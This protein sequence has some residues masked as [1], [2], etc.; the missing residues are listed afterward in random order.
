M[1]VKEYLEKD[2]DNTSSLENEGMG[3][4]LENIFLKG[5]MK[6]YEFGKKTGL[7]DLMARQMEK[8]EELKEEHPALW[9]VKHI[10]TGAIKGITGNWWSNR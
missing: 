10:G 5:V 9:T 7:Y 2:L 4:K 8:D 6:W 3:T 1:T